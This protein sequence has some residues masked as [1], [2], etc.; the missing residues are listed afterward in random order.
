M[1]LKY[2]YWIL[3]KPKDMPW[4]QSFHVE[5]DL[6]SKNIGAIITPVKQLSHAAETATCVH[7]YG[8]QAVR[9]EIDSAHDQICIPRVPEK[10]DN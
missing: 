6:Q 8:T 5:G 4:C 7:L 10:S 9:L 1:I 2:F 3:H